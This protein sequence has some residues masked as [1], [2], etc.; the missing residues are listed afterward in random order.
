ME[1]Q[2]IFSFMDRIQTEIIDS[3]VYDEDIVED[4]Q[5]AKDSLGELSEQLT[6]VEYLSEEET[7]EGEPDEDRDNE[8]EYEYE[9][10]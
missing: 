4:A 1:P 3:G 9:D 5:E 8:D 10:R 6:G 2:D 7:K